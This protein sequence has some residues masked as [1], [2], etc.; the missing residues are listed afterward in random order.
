VAPERVRIGEPAQSAL[1]GKGVRT[2]VILDAAQAG[3]GG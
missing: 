2:A 3:R 1:D